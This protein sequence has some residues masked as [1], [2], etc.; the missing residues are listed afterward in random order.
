MNEAP[1]LNVLVGL[2]VYI[3][4]ELHSRAKQ[5][6]F[7]HGL[8][9]QSGQPVSTYVGITKVILRVLVV[10]VSVMLVWVALVVVVVVVLVVES[11]VS[12]ISI[13]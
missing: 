6:Y 4:T 1:P 13:V 12:E 10:V 5:H 7:I 8:K 9:S 2:A 3:D 11:V